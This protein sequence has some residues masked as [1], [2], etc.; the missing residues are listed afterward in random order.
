MTVASSL[1]DAWVVHQTT[2]RLRFRLPGK[3]KDR[4][5]FVRLG[6]WI[7]QLPGIVAYRGNP[8]TATVLLVHQQPFGFEYLQR[9][10]LEDGWFRLHPTE[11]FEPFGDALPSN[12]LAFAQSLS[13][14]VDYKPAAFTML[15]SLSSVQLARGEVLPPAATLLWYAIGLLDQPNRVKPDATESDLV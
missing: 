5:F 8:V 14:M 11:T 10:A 3:R 1:L 4:E 13:Q 7:T 2:G 15:L 9:V 12:P 6:E